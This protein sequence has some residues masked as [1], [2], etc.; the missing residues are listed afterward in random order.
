MDILINLLPPERQKEIKNLRYIGIVLKIGTMALFALVVLASFSYACLY[1][2][3]VEEKS[4]EEELVRFKQA[5]SYQETQVAQDSLR[6]YNKIASKVKSGLKKQ[7][8]YWNIIYEINS[9]VPADV[10]LTNFGVSADGMIVLKGLAYT[11]ADFLAFKD[12]LEN[13]ELLKNLESPISNLVMEKDVSF[14]FTAEI[15]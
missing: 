14:E 5:R 13:S 2:I 7:K 8:E 12:G 9:K 6:E 11:R 4:V 10:V 15:K 3:S 1:F